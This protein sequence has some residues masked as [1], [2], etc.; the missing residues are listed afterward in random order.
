MRAKQEKFCSSQNRN[1]LGRPPSW[2]RA[3]V[4]L[5]DGKMG[6]RPGPA[7]TLR[8]F[9]KHQ[10]LLHRHAPAFIRHVLDSF[11]QHTLSAAQAAEQLGLSPS[12]LYALASAYNT[13]RARKQSRLWSP[14]TSGG[15]H[16]A[17]WPASR[18][19]PTA[20]SLPKP[21]ASTPS[22]STAPRSGVGPSQ[23]NPPTP[24][25]PKK[26]RPPP[27]PPLAVR[28]HRRTLAA[29]RLAPPLV[30]PLQAALPHAQPARRLQPPLHRLEDL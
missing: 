4:A 24:S 15:D 21:C 17:A 14:G 7:A 13:A 30:P 18:P 16:A 29:R 19:V 3:S 25:P 6:G 1:P 5:P 27:R 8:V 26:F 22:N 28:Q 10:Q 12:R 9:E 20:S 11:R 23:T 2:R